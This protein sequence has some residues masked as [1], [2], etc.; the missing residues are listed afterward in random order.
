MITC[1]LVKSYATSFVLL[2]FRGIKNWSKASPSDNSSCIGIKNER[3]GLTHRCNEPVLHF[4]AHGAWG[5]R[6]YAVFWTMLLPGIFF[7]MTGRGGEDQ[8]ES[9]PDPV[10]GTGL[11]PADVRMVEGDDEFLIPEVFQSHLPTT[12]EKYRLRLWVHPHLGDY[13]NR[14]HLR[15]TTGV[16]YGL[17]ENWEISGSSDLYFS[18]GNGD[19]P[20]FD[21]FGAANLQLGTK[22][23]LGQPWFSG[24]DI[25]TGFDCKFPV[26]RPPAELTDGLRHFMPFITFSHRLEQHK[27]Q[28]IF[29]GLRF[30]E[31]T[32]TKLQG[33]FGDNSFKDSSAGITGGWV[34][35]HKNWHY[36]VEVSY[37]TTRLMG[38]SSVDRITV[39]PGV[40]WE[41]PSRR[42]PQ[43]K[44]H[45][46]VGVSANSTYGPGGTSLGASLKLRYTRDLKKPNHRPSSIPV[47]Q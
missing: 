28:R 3:F 42:N 14:D 21:K 45:W 18:H 6:K 5:V 15:M 20:A 36:T 47:R 7:P 9:S 2:A 8:A 25:G 26:G 41:I 30:D 46:L 10:I 34:I 12:L 24:W 13:E 38:H 29:W 35:D 19:V 4:S 40:I 22:V 1:R 27:S 23:N 43:I 44:G 16:R 11:F 33:E 31:V 39:R 32:H 17:S 37:D